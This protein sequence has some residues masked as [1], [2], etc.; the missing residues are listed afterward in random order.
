MPSCQRRRDGR[1][2]Q[3]PRSTLAPRPPATLAHPLAR[4]F[5]RQVYELKK[6]EI[7][8]ALDKARTQATQLNDKY[9]HKVGGARVVEAVG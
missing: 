3:H 9:L 5:R 4:S 2:C 6:P 7:D 1:E 8:A